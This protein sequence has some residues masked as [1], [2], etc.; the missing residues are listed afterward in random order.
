MRI[1]VLCSAPGLDGEAYRRDPSVHLPEHSWETHTLTRAGAAREVRALA[2]RG[3]DVFVNLCDGA[4]GEDRAGVEVVQ[5]LQQLGVAYT[6]ADEAFYEPTREAMKAA[7]RARGVATPRAVFAGDLAA[8]ARAAE[9]LR[10]PMIVKHPCSY[11]SVGMTRA[12]RV[13]D[14]GQLL[15]QAA[16]TIACYG[17]ALIEEF[18]EGRE[19]TVLVA[20][21]PEDPRE[22]IAFVPA[23]FGF[24][25]G[26]C[27]KHHDLKWID[28]H[29]MTWSPVECPR[30]AAR[31]QDISR[32]QFLGLGGRSYGRCDIRMD[33]RGELY[34]L[35]INPNCGVFYAPE[36]PGSAD[37]ILM[38]D[39]AG[40]RGFLEL[41]LR[42]ALAAAAFKPAFKPARRGVRTRRRPALAALADLS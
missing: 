25:A 15:A 17:R 32:K 22:P 11:S 21:N 31:L 19:F 5:T 27:F 39:R 40:H 42:A 36:D 33:A 37:V 24:P 14:R 2:R 20:E 16:R 18:I 9:V 1:C 12:S 7:C 26:E 13:E 28:Y 38:A 6:G 4:I 41:I 34:M 29:Q 35:E 30:L 10:F 8:A 23:E 3:F